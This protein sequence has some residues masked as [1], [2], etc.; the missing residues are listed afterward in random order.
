MYYYLIFLLL[1]SLSNKTYSFR[2]KPSNPKINHKKLFLSN[3]DKF[4]NDPN[5]FEKDNDETKYYRFGAFPRLETPN[6]YGELTWYAIG[7][8]KDFNDKPKRITLRDINYIIWKD[9]NKDSYYGL[10]DVCSHQGSS[11]QNGCFFSDKIVCPYHGYT[12]EGNY[13][14]LIDIPG[15]KINSNERQNIQSFKV[16]EKYGMLYLNTIPITMEN[17]NLIDENKIWIEPEA[18]DNSQKPVY[19]SENFYHYSKFVT[20]NSL[21]ICHIG[22]VH[23]FG[24]KKHPNPIYNSKIAKIDDSSFHYK[25]IYEY[26]AG[27]ESIVSKT[28]KFKNII[29]EN[30]YILPHTTVARVKFGNYSSTIIT[31]AQPISVFSTKLYVKA[32]RNYW[33]DNAKSNVFGNVVNYIGDMITLHTMR[34]TLNQDKNIIDNLDKKDYDMMHGKFSI[35]YDMMSNHYKHNYKKFYEYDRFNF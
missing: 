15:L 17:F 7:F 10:R 26:I 22:F 31:V 28:Y 6:D 4:N 33:F 2:P 1:L 30:E 35:K 5:I 12:F 18:K 20:V 21:D 11:F 16:V 3:F 19:L 34:T 14:K 24:N 8:S 29:V 25:I 9:K 13:G 27:E 32:Y 23:T